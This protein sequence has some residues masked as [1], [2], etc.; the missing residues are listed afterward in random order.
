M[1]GPERARTAHEP[2]GGCGS[3]R[4][5]TAPCSA[6]VPAAALADDAPSMTGRGAPDDLDERLEDDPTEDPQAGLAG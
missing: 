4:D 6:E 3:A 1:T 2:S 5:S